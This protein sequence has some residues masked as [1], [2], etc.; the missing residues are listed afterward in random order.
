MD[1]KYFNDNEQNDL[2]LFY[3]FNE[4]HHFF[5]CITPTKSKESYDA[6][7]IHK[8]RQFAVELKHRFVPL[9]KYKT[10]FIE[11]YKLAQLY[12]QWVLYKKEPLYVCFLYDAVVIFNLNKLKHQPRLTIKN[13]KSKGYEIIQERERR[14]ELSLEDAVIYKN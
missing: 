10:L 12:L 1:E 2:Q 6:T 4:K 11:D 14:F 5:S 7:A 8:N 3:E 9:S 13:I